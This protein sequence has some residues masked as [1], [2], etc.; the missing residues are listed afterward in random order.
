MNF[1]ELKAEY[2]RRVEEE[3][4]DYRVKI[5]D[6]LSLNFNEIIKGAYIIFLETEL[7]GYTNVD[8][9]PE[10][11]K[12]IFKKINDHYSDWNIHKKQVEKKK[13]K[14]EN[15]EMFRFSLK[16]M[17]EESGKTVEVENEKTERTDIL[18]L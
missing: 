5:D 8:F 14:G 9:T 10:L 17:D 2:E 11:K 16:K 12:D 4:Q 1:Q 15:E 18:D 7:T 13:R 3:F 6:K